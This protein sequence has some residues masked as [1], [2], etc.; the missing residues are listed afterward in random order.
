MK[1]DVDFR[2]GLAFDKMCW[3]KSCLRCIMVIRDQEQIAYCSLREKRTKFSNN[4][5]KQ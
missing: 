1:N 2:D 4:F 3:G 5:K